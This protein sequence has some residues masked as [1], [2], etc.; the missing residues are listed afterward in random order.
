MTLQRQMIFWVGA[1]VVFVAALWLLSNIMLPFVAG[2]ALA[3]LL[4]P[5][6]R[7]A[8][9]FGVPRAISALF[10]VTMAL[11][12]LV[13]ATMVV[14]PILGGQF[15]AFMEKLPAYV[16]RLQSLVTDPSRPWL[17]KVFGEALPDPN[18]S[19]AGLVSQSSGWITAFLRS[20]WSG[21][22]ALFSIL[23]IFV[24]APVVAI[25]LLC[26]WDDL[27]KT[28]DSWIPLPH[29]E[30]VRGLA[31]E[32]D[33]AIA[34]FVRGQALVCI[35]LA[36]FYAAGLTLSGLNFGLLI[37]LMTGILAF[38]PYVGALTGF[39]VA[40]I[41]TVAQFWPDWT[42]M[43]MVLGVFVVGQVLEGYV[44][45]PKLVGSKVGLHPV[46]LMFALIAF[47]YL[48]G[49]VGFLIAIPVA[50]AIGVL[51]RFAIRKY[52]MSPLFTGESSH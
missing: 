38:V 46:W 50:A 12:A 33:A 7:R 31:R 51:A 37:G 49:F 42:S 15:S 32:M 10:I 24:I 17:S 30:T 48:L 5:I 8:E 34:G 29:R 1:L 3:Y 23:S 14:A 2:M 20:L 40:G 52:L 16:S 11:V 25:Y 28:L 22:R 47:G 21:G 27:V 39:L 6:A 44:L 13:A 19:I 9:R 43:L 41:V 35:V 18:A 45:S 36:A 26:D 4:D